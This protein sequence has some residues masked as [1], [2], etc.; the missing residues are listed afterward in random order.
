MTLIALE[1]VAGFD[2][3]TKENVLIMGDLSHYIERAWRQTATR[4][5][6]NAL[7]AVF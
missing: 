7:M 3:F 6:A 4:M 2:F 5:K 1:L